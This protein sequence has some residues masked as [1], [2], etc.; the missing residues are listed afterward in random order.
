[1]VTR[2]LWNQTLCQFWGCLQRLGFRVFGFSGLRVS[3]IREHWLP[4]WKNQKMSL[5]FWGEGEEG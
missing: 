4:P 2:W 1:M 3:G 5:T